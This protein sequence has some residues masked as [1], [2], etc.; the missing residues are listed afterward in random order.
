MSRKKKILPPMERVII[1]SGNSSFLSSASSLII[2]SEYYAQVNCFAYGRHALHELRN[3][4]RYNLLILDERITDISATEFVQTLTQLPV[5]VDNSLLVVCLGRNINRWCLFLEPYRAVCLTIPFA[6]EEFVEK[7]LSLPLQRQKN[8]AEAVT[9]RILLPWG[10]PE[11]S[12]EL[13]LLIMAVVINVMVQR[14]PTIA[15]SI[16]KKV[17]IHHA[18]YY[19]ESDRECFENLIAQFEAIKSADYRAFKRR[20]GFAMRKNAP[21]EDLLRRLI[22]EVALQ[23]S[24]RENRF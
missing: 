17:D 6:S 24:F 19:S 12:F 5:Y 1:V 3:G 16:A 7:A 11:S 10:V 18:F 22:E 15:A 21:A 23:T 13:R 2:E 8:Q 20:Y 9:K 14:H 4:L